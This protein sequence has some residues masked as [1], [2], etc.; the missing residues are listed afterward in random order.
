MTPR[1]RDRLRRALVIMGGLVVA[2]LASSL[3]LEAWLSH[4]DAKRYPPPGQMVDIGGRRLHLQC[5]GVGTPTVV[6]EMGAGAWSVY[7]AGI[8]DELAGT[9][10]TCVYDRAG[11][12]WSDPGP[13]TISSDQLVDDLYLLL[14]RSGEQGPFVLVGHSLGGWIVRLYEARFPGDVAALALV[15]SAHPRQ[16]EELPPAV[17]DFV[18]SSAGGLRFLAWSGHFGTLRLMA[19]RLATQQLPESVMPAYRASAI[20]PSRYSTMAAVIDATPG[21]ASDVEE[22]PGLG[23]LPLLVVSAG[24]SFDALRGSGADI[25]FDRANEVW[26]RLQEEL[27][28]LSTRSMHLV[29]PAST[30]DIHVDDPEIIVR[31]LKA[32]VDTVRLDRGDPPTAS[33]AASAHLEG[34]P[35]TAP[36]AAASGA[37]PS[38]PLVSDPEVDSLLA[39]V[40]RAYRDMDVESFVGLFSEDFEQLDVPRRVEIQGR[41]AWRKQTTAINGAHTRMGRIHHG[42]A[43]L[44]NSVVVELEWYGTLRGEAFGD[45]LGPRSYRYTGLG[46]LELEDGKISRQVI[47]GDVPTLEEQL[48]SSLRR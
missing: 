41:D 6:M 10:R 9:T 14:R 42:R 13:S 45:G 17:W 1:G 19:D 11:L 35:A 31:G 3:A 47:Y 24:R 38:L 27:G 15:E 28:A 37:F 32:L 12:G 25:P 40:E 20:R 8:R 43:R 26:R 29:S 21:I 48:Q 46:L 4:R 36:W 2:T 33:S 30:H 7:W 5:R 44:G 22:L 23:S 16:W 34:P 39:N 18:G